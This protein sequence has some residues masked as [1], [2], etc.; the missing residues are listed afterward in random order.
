M[1]KGHPY[2]GWIEEVRYG[3]DKHYY[4]ART[5]G[6]L[7]SVTCCDACKVSFGDKPVPYHAED[8]GPTL[9][10]Y[11]ASCVPLCH[12]CHA[13][14]HA[15]FAT[16]NLWF[17]FLTQLAEN[18]IDE[19]L[20]PQSTQIAA[21]LSKFKNRPDIETVEI[22]TECNI[23]LKSLPMSE[24]SGPTKVATLLIIDQRTGLTVEVPDWIIYGENLER[25]TNEERKVLNERGLSVDDF[26]S[27]RISVPPNSSGTRRYDRLYLKSDNVIT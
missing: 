22:P 1:A 23:Y 6:V 13:M 5:K 4:H 3:R 12:R 18:S 7:R 17:L 26:L 11:W 25:L 15:R 2:N 21:L 24:Y 20:F 14:V 10:D 27:G 9:E 8:Y 16:P 19:K